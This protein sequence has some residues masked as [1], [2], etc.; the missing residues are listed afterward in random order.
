MDV[1]CAAISP[2][3]RRIASG[4]YDQSVKL[5]DLE[6][7]RLIRTLGAHSDPVC[8]VAFNADGTRVLS[9]ASDGT[10]KVWNVE[11]APIEVPDAHAGFVKGVAF[12]PDNR[13]VTASSDKTVK[14]WDLAT[15]RVTRTLTGH[16]DKIA[17]LALSAD[18]RRA[19]TG[20]DDGVVKAWD[21][22]TG[23]PLFEI[24]GHEGIVGAV[25]ASPDGRLLASSAGRL[26]LHDAHTGERLAVFEEAGSF[27]R[28]LVFTPD[29]TRL[30]A[31]ASAGLDYHIAIW[32]VA[33]GT[34]AGALRGHQHFIQTI[35]VSPDGR[36]VASGSYDGVLK[37]WDLE[38]ERELLSWVGHESSPAAMAIS[39][40]GRRLLTAS[41]DCRLIVW[42]IR[43]GEL[44]ARFTFDRSGRSCA[45]GPGG[46][47]G[48][49][50]KSGRV[51]FLTLVT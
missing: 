35:A 49:G 36:R 45:F 22:D 21:I 16:A 8:T 3:G 12:T 23:E 44:V 31:G 1:L 39:D 46:L 4:S 40:D 29:G 25:A 13:A 9:W 48:G 34:F 15:G 6:E 41:G 5:W 30:L 14:I 10:L 43:T 28:G 26:H 18:G 33:R 37:V 27:D 51:Y 24:P 17:S 20:A 38:A 50:D 7:G 42:D 19:F 32:D 11:A 47:I 2:D